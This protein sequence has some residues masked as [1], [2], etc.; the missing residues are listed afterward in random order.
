MKLN[1][2]CELMNS[3]DYKDR[4]LAEYY[5]LKIRLDKLRRFNAKIEAANLTSRYDSK[6]ADM[7][8]HDCPEAFLREQEKIMEKYL[9][10]LE[11]R[12]HIEGIELG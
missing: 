9:H 12:A 1:D 3:A 7:P 11:M 6:K 10:I 5:Q 2:T 4:F 8:E